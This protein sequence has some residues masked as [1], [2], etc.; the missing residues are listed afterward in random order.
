MLKWTWC[1]APTDSGFNTMGDFVQL[2]EKIR[3]LCFNFLWGAEEGMGVLVYVARVMH[4]VYLLLYF[5]GYTGSGVGRERLV[6]RGV[7]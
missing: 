1:T 7:G 2:F 5:F 6:C 4:A 3:V